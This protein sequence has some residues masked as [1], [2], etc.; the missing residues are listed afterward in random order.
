VPALVCITSIFDNNKD[1]ECVVTVLTEGLSERSVEKFRRLAEAY[2][3][4]VDIRAIDSSCFEA[5]V[6]RGRYPVSMYFRFLLPEIL[7]KEDKVLYLDCDIMVR[8]SMRSLFDEDLTD[9]ACGVVVDQQCD[10]T[11]ILN[12]LRIESDYFNSGVMLFNL[13][14]WRTNEYAK[15]IISFIEQNPDK[16]I[17]PDQDALNVVLEGKVKYLD[18]KYNMQE[19]WLTMLDYARFHYTRHVGLQRAVAD[20]SIVHFCVGDKPWYSECRNPYRGEYLKY[21]SRH[22]FIGFRERPHYS[23]GYFWLEAQIM[24]LKRWQS[25]CVKK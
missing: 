15:K 13:D 24:R 23:K 1:D 21:A 25:K 2:G 17:F 19:M 22:D 10:D 12:R 6:T 11:Q 3:Q 18:L 8:H 14:E 5:M 20:P 7:V 16:C 9:K 4:T